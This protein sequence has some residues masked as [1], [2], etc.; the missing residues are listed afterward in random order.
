M[1]CVCYVERLVEAC[2]KICGVCKGHV[3]HIIPWLLTPVQG[4]LGCLARFVLVVLIILFLY[5]V[6]LFYLCC[7]LE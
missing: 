6:I 5:L 1:K 2:M 3:M 7:I 4:F